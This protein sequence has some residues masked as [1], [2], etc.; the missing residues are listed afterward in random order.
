[1]TCGR[2]GLA[3]PEPFGAGLRCGCCGLALE[4]PSYPLNLPKTGGWMVGTVVQGGET[5]E[6]PRKGVSDGI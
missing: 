1:M 5:L 3:R 2:C 6:S 4:C